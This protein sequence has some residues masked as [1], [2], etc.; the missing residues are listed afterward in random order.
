VTF[1]LV[2][3]DALDSCY[4]ANLV[5]NQA[6][7]LEG[8]GSRSLVSKTTFVNCANCAVLGP[9][10]GSAECPATATTTTTKTS[11]SSLPGDILEE[12]K[13]ETLHLKI[14][15]SLASSI[16]HALVLT[17]CPTPSFY[18]ADNFDD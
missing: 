16:C 9:V 10:S 5:S 11:V 4:A 6:Y 1:S 13:K 8:D 18:F 3:D 17:M 12:R 14:P 2:T 7:T 15:A